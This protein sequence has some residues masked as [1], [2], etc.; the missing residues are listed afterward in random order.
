[1]INEIRNRNENN[2]DT[3]IRNKDRKKKKNKKNRK[4]TERD[5]RTCIW[6]L[7][8]KEEKNTE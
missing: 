2:R 3:M 4:N 6:D 8:I 5:I 7:V 1:M